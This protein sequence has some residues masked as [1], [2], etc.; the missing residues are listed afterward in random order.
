M[1]LYLTLLDES[2]QELNYP[3]FRRIPIDEDSYHGHGHVM[4]RSGSPNFEFPTYVG[5]G[6]VTAAYTAVV[7]DDGAFLLVSP[8][9][10][11]D[12]CVWATLKERLDARGVVLIGLN[13]L[14]AGSEV[15][16]YRYISSEEVE[17]GERYIVVA[18]ASR[19]RGPL[20]SPA[21][22]PAAYTIFHDPELVGFQVIKPAE[23]V[24]MG[25]LPGQ[26]FIDV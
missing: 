12:C 16:S 20:L 9:D 1:S 2:R 7:G 21:A 25:P 4:T 13:E 14:Q 22:G 11:D 5:G 10:P 8:F 26:R 23:P 19:G 3:S 15:I 24:R 6:R 18:A 17:E